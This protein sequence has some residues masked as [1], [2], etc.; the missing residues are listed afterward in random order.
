MRG[1]SFLCNESYCRRDRAAAR[2]GNEPASSTGNLGLRCALDA[3]T[4]SLMG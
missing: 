3:N 4:F 2:S 1:G